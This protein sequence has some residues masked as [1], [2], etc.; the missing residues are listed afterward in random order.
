MRRLNFP[1]GK[2]AVY[3][4]PN[5]AV[6]KQRHNIIHKFAYSRGFF[7]NTSLVRSVTNFS[8]A[9]LSKRQSVPILKA[10]ILPLRA[11]L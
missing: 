9:P 7:F 6:R 1:G 8:I 4:W 10:G 2:N 11:N 3:I 5:L